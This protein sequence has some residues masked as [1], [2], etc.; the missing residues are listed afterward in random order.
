MESIASLLQGQ[1]RIGYQMRP[2]GRN[3]INPPADRTA[4]AD[5]APSGH[6]LSGLDFVNV[7]PHPGFSRLNRA[8]QRV[9]GLVKMFGGVLVF[10]RIAATHV[11]ANQTEPQVH[12]GVAH[13]H[14]FFTN[15]LAGGSYFDLVEV[16]ALFGH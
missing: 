4:K 14:A 7:A 3:R 12:P 10:R 16:R 15:V 1:K 2:F 8:D 11:P 9:L 5:K 13:L 6:E